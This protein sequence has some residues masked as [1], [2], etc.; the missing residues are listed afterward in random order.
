VTTQ[1][2]KFNRAARAE[3]VVPP[4][5]NR[6][7]PATAK[8]STS[9]LARLGVLGMEP[10]EPVILGALISGE[11][12]LL[13]GPH[14]T[15]KS[16]LLNRLCI[17]L[18]LESWRHYNASLL[19]FDDL[20]G[21]PLPDGRG[22][23]NYVRTPSSI[24]D[25]QAVFIDE[26]SRCRPDMQNKLFP[27]IHE[28]R[29]QGIELPRLIYR[30]SAMNP[31]QQD[32][33]ETTGGYRGSEPLDIAL[34]D[35]FA[36]V[37][38]M[39][40]WETLSQDQQEQVILSADT[41]VCP[42]AARRLRADVASGQAL[43]PAVRAQLAPQL[44]AYIR[45]ILA[46]QAGLVLSGRRAAMLLRNIVATHTARLLTS[47]DADAAD[48]ALLALD[49]SLPQRATEVAVGQIQVLAAHR[50]AWKTAGLGAQDPRFYLRLERDPLRRALRAA[51][52]NSLP[53][54]ELSSLVADAI[55]D[56]PRGRCHALVATLFESGAAGRL[57]AAVA[58]QCAQLYAVVATTH[59]VRESVAS[60][61]LRFRVWQRVVAVLA[62]LDP[63]N[64]EDALASN[65]LTGLFAANE[66]TT[67][68]EVDRV[69]QDWREAREQTQGVM[70]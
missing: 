4:V 67:E 9:L 68:A 39:P 3:S 35:R 58:E 2:S 64:P 13:I 11:P 53:D 48:S 14:G 69:L 51:R 44:V 66:L 41:E 10:I 65:L 21:Y 26:I 57:V 32:D 29:V 60:Q 12:V 23:L 20:V 61:S 25:A 31:C 46:L 54:V 18:G 15:G 1:Q 62:R 42:A 17:A 40:T 70:A 16:Y 33:D 19:N 47:P 5:S 34:A 36:F 49:H 59:P 7:K 45:L 43:L 55:A 38:A 37:I 50:E 30:W 22:G 28:R 52:L 6:G 63:G 56:L 24:W 27:I 8:T